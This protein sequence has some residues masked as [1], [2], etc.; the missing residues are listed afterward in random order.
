[1]FRAIFHNYRSNALYHITINRE[2]GVPDFVVLKGDS[3]NPLSERTKLGGII[4]H[5]LR[6]ISK[7]NPLIR[8][9]QY[10]LMPDHVHFILHVKDSLDKPVG[11]YIGAFKVRVRQAARSACGIDSPIF[12]ENFYDRIIQPWHSLDDVYKYIR[13]NPA[14]LLARRE[15]P[16]YFQ[17]VNDYVIDG[18]AWSLYGNFDL[19]SNPFVSQV[20]IHRKDTEDE[21]RKKLAYWEHLMRNG[22]VLVSPFISRAEKAVR[23]MAFEL[24]GRMIL[25]INEPLSDRYKPGGENFEACLRGDLLVLAPAEPLAEC[26]ETWLYLNNL[27]RRIAARHRQ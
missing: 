23:N 3:K 15:N 24:H 14:R 26:R 19:L 13:E 18:R 5:E 10:V 25:V 8:M 1:M 27:S 11:N 6:M 7:L 21:R 22:G 20:V 4:E 16:G 17:R 12:A 2:N 9:Y